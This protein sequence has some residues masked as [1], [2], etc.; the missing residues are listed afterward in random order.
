MSSAVAPSDFKPLQASE[1]GGFA[2]FAIV[3]AAI[4]AMSSA[5]AVVLVGAGDPRKPRAVLFS[6][7]TAREQ[8]LAATLRAGHRPLRSGLAAHIVIVAP[9]AGG[10]PA[11]AWPAGAWLMLNL[12]GLFGCLGRQPEAV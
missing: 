8:A 6:P 1:P 9:P 12:D 4:L 7:W 11:F 2:Q 10:E 3:A 5:L